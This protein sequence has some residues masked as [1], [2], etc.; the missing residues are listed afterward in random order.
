MACDFVWL[1]CGLHRLFPQK[2]RKLN[3]SQVPLPLRLL[4][5]LSCRGKAV[6]VHCC[7]MAWT[8]ASVNSQ[9][10]ASFFHS[11]GRRYLEASRHST[12]RS[13]CVSCRWS[14]LKVRLFPEGSLGSL[15]ERW[16]CGADPKSSN[17]GKIPARL[18]PMI[19]D[20]DLESL[21]AQD[22]L[23]TTLVSAS[24]PCLDLWTPSCSHCSS[25]QNSFPRLSVPQLHCHSQKTP[26]RPP[27]PGR[28]PNSSLF[29]VFI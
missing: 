24:M 20:W 29:S 4:A 9:Q 10:Y 26:Q 3:T 1:D 13:C 28:L 14:C 27:L 6:P 12:E 17:L 16:S 19:L 7:S 25:I 23:S 8:W 5:A 15:S 18:S 2:H 21:P 22:L 11:C